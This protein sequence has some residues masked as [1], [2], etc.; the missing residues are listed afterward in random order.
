ML[1]QEPI[2]TFTVRALIFALFIVADLFVKAWYLWKISVVQTQG[3]CDSHH[4]FT[5][6]RHGGEQS[7][8]SCLC[9]SSWSQK[10]ETPLHFH[11]P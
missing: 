10:P 8:C 5:E 9:Q 11:F 6:S 1:R 4:F 3:Q 7:N 2:W